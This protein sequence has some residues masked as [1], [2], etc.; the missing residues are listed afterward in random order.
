MSSIFS[1][2]FLLKRLMKANPLLWVGEWLFH[3]SFAFVLLRHL[4]YFI[5]PAPAWLFDFDV[6][7][8]ISGFM[9]FSSL[10]FILA[11]KMFIER[12][13]FSSYNFSLLALLVFI[14]VTGLLMNMIL[15]TDLVEIKF[16]AMG[17][18]TFTPQ[19]LPVSSI[20]FTHFFSFI[21]FILLLPSHIFTAP[22]TILEAFRRDEDIKTIMHDEKK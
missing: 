8:I 20:F 1:E 14:S 5:E 17:I 19:S 18:A 22:I 3:I 16:F 11:V 15:K 6:F 4:R 21:I 13:Y 7:G 10:V 2:L 12:A 9:L